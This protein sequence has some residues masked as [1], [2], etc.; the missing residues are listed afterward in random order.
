[1]EKRLKQSKLN[2]APFLIR[3]ILINTGGTKKRA[4]II[5]SYSNSGIFGKNEG[6]T[7]LLWFDALKDSIRKRKTIE[8]ILTNNWNVENMSYFPYLFYKNG[9]WSDA[10]HYMLLLTNPATKRHEYPEVSYG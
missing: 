3:N 2:L 1:M 8:R 6:E 5:P 4:V 9:Y 7:F 10:L